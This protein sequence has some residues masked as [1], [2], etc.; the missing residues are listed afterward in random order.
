MS[1]YLFETA[2]RAVEMA[3]EEDKQAA[4]EFIGSA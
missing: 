3:I 2:K 4:L 1:K